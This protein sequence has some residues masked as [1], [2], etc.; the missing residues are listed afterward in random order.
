LLPIC[1]PRL[2]SVLA[3]IGDEVGAYSAAMQIGVRFLKF[4]IL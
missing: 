4:I 2:N 1:H 3:W